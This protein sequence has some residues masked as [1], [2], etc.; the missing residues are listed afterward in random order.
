MQQ[1]RVNNL[2]HN[3]FILFFYSHQP[4]AYRS[5]IYCSNHLICW[6]RAFRHCICFSIPSW[7]QLRFVSSFNSISYDGKKGV[8]K[9]TPNLNFSYVGMTFLLAHLFG[10]LNVFIARSW[11]TVAIGTTPLDWLPPRRHVERQ[12]QLE[13]S[14][15]DRQVLRHLKWREP[16]PK[17]EHKKTLKIHTV[18]YFVVISLSHLHTFTSAM[19]NLHWFYK[20]AILYN[21]NRSF[22]Y[23][24]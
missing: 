2:Q 18:I 15:D 23:A 10:S 19:I 24:E 5:S 21:T 4:Q 16:E 3:K 14:G 12:Y 17:P 22:L 6:K 20:F 7:F 11:C 13:L 8:L 9:F 1:V